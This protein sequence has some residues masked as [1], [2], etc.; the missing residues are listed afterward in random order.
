LTRDSRASF[1]RPFVRVLLSTQEAPLGKD[2]AKEKGIRPDIPQWH[3]SG[4]LDDA[5]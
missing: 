2:L 1:F 5:C 3:D 4:G